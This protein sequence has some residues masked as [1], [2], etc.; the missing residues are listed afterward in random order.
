MSRCQG[1]SLVL[2][3]ALVASPRVSAEPDAPSVPARPAPLSIVV[4][5]APIEE[6]YAML[7]RR[8]RVNIVLG[9]GVSS[10][11]SV[12]LYDV[13]VDQAIRSIAE[14]GGYVAERRGAHYAIVTAEEAGRENLLRSY[15]V[16]YSDAEKVAAILQKYLS[17]MGEITVL[18]ERQMIVIEDRSDVVRR[19]EALLAELDREPQQIL[20]EA[21]I[22]EIQL[23]DDESFGIDWS[24]SFHDQEG[25][26]GLRALTSTTGFFFELVNENI[27]LTLTALADQGRVRTLATPTLLALENQE[28]EVVIGDRLGFRVTTTINQ[29]TTESVEFLES[30]VILK[31]KA[32]VDR[33][34]RVRLEVHPEVSVG[35]L[36]AGLPSQKTT[37]VTTHLLAEDSQP[38]LIGGLIRDRSSH[39]REGVPFLSSIPILGHAFKTRVRSDFMTETVVLLTAHVTE[40]SQRA[41]SAERTRWVPELERDLYERRERMRREFDSPAAPEGEQ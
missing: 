26:F 2:L 13:N 16:H 12:A 34:R 28:A 18:K 6:I 36:T 8:E 3:L 33:E 25:S 39:D 7:S 31:I 29:V 11:V 22:L 10:R 14:A 4:Q 5:D 1:A 37:E 19:L 24:K 15:L 23:S 41:H 17:R 40:P 9:K 21:R 38:I 27:D 32:A 30:G 20:I 35:V